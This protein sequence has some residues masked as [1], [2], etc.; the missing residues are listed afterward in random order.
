MLSPRARLNKDKPVKTRL[1][2]IR[3]TRNETNSRARRE[4][5]EFK[6]KVDRPA[7]SFA[8]EGVHERWW[9]RVGFIREK[10]RPERG[11]LVSR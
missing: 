5:S 4:A 2:Y 6:G 8:N 10:E 1:T 7:L 9:G 3:S 11:K